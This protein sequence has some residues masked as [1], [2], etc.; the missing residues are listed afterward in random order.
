MNA[1]N[2]SRRNKSVLLIFPFAS[3]FDMAQ[4]SMVTDPALI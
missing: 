4:L 3:G 2:K 1:K